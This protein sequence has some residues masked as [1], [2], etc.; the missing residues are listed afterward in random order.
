MPS[1][2]LSKAKIIM[3][4]ANARNLP[5]P[6]NSV[7]C[8]VTSPPYW[9]LRAYAGEQESVWCVANECEHE[10]TNQIVVRKGSTNGRAGS[11]LVSSGSYK[12][13]LAGDTNNVGMDR[14]YRGDKNDIC[15]LCGAWRGSYGLEPTIEMYVEHTVDILREIRRVL[16]PDGV[17][18]WNI[19]DSYSGNGG[20]AKPGGPNAKCGNTRSGVGSSVTTGFSQRVPIGLKPKDLCLIPARVALAAQADGWWVRSIIVWA[21]P[22]AMPESVTDRPTDSYEH[23][24]MLTKSQRYFWDADAVREQGSTTNRERQMP[25]GL[26][27]PD[28]KA[29]PLGFDNSCGANG[30]R[31]MRNVWTFATNP[32]SGAHVATFPEELPRRCIL[33]ATSAKGACIQCGAPWEKAMGWRPTCLCRGQHGKTQPCL[34]MDTFAG[35]GTTGRVAIELGRSAA[36]F[37]IAYGD[38][39]TYAGLARKRTTGVQIGLLEKL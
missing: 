39:D 1:L 19:G 31:N 13:V 11:S 32:Y 9:G 12:T 18:F 15:A 30:T 38:G 17:V 16:R 33:A 6:D 26:Y 4:Q 23:I 34:V 22:N 7:Q 25:N 21:K 5:L 2:D 3:Q 29:S 10:W 28:N 36:L 37:D 14:Q 35:S 20:N 24:I 27:Q 8:V